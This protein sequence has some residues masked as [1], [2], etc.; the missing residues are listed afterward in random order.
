MPDTMPASPAISGRKAIASF[1]QEHGFYLARG[2]VA[3]GMLEGL[4]HD[5]D[6]RFTIADSIP[7]EYEPGDVV[8]FSYLSVH[9]S[10]ANRDDRPRKSVLVQLYSGSDALVDD[11]QHPNAN[12]VL[13]GWNH[14]MT[15]ERANSN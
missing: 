3:R 1:Y 10:L 15:R 7:V 13:R 8:L 5:F 4:Q 9:A 14:H 11:A 2:V 6:Q 12:L